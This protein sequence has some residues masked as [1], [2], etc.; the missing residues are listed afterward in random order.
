[1]ARPKKDST[2]KTAKERLADA[3]LRLLEKYDVSKISVEM[4]C[5]EAHCNRGTFY[6]HFSDMDSLIEYVVESVFVAKRFPQLTFDILTGTGD[7]SFSSLVTSEW[8]E[9]LAL[10]IRHGKGAL[11]ETIWRY[12]LKVWTAILCSDG[13]EMSDQTKLILEYQL[14]GMLSMLSYVGEQSMKGHTMTP[15]IVFLS[16][17]SRSAIHQICALE[18]I[19]EE[20][21][22]ARFGMVDE[23]M[24]ISEG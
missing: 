15:P 7:V 1:M 8:P 9:R 17:V 11:V 10:F 16:S 23:I 3:F 12:V 22:K 2:E 6:Y 18:G 19:T 13:H 14:S 20:E 4:L 5:Q 24:G 21:L